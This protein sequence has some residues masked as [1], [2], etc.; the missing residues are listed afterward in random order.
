[1]YEECNSLVSK[2]SQ[3]CLQFEFCRINNCYIFGNWGG[4]LADNQLWG[5]AIEKFTISL[6]C[7][8]DFT[9]EPEIIEYQNAL[10]YSI[11]SSLNGMGID[12]LDDRKYEASINKFE[13]AIAWCDDITMKNYFQSNQL[14]AY[15]SWATHLYNTSSFKEAFIVSNTAV[16]KFSSYNEFS[17]EVDFLREI[18][19]ECKLFRD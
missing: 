10:K 18:M 13:E 16:D 17:E 12:L 14:I 3:Y 4:D 1:E 9:S 19:K 6:N 2:Y 11:A 15:V 7:L 5:D 8:D